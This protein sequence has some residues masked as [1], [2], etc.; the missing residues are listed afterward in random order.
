MDNKVLSQFFKQNYILSREK[1][2]NA[3]ISFRLQGYGV[4]P[5]VMDRHVPVETTTKMARPVVTFFGQ[6]LSDLLRI[7]MKYTIELW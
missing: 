6:I 5:A 3:R 1:F 7:S 4:T 2:S